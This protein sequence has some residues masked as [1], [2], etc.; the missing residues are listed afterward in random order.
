MNSKIAGH[1]IVVATRNQVS[2]DLGGEVAILDVK[3][4]IYYGLNDIGARIWNLIQEPQ[5]VEA[6]CQRILEEYAVEADRC[7]QDVLTLL[8]EL[9]GNGLIEVRDGTDS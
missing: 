9:V 7:A 1:S 6:I 8:R 4:G 5:S 3:S 2:C